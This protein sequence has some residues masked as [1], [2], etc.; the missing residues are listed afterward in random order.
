MNFYKSLKEFTDCGNIPLWTELQVVI[1][2]RKVLFSS[3]VQWS[4]VIELLHKSQGHQSTDSGR[5]ALS[6]GL[7]IVIDLRQVL[8]SSKIQL[9]K[10]S[11]L[12]NKSQ[13]RLL[14]LETYHHELNSGSDLQ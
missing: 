14:T 8:Y 9:F 10:V 7:Q 11:E 13:G 6:S 5:L 1:D 4:G 12:L 2:S 3:E